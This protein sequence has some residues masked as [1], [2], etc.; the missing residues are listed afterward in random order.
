MTEVSKKDVF[1]VPLTHIDFQSIKSYTTF[2]STLTVL[3][4][5]I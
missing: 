4:S 1:Q 3:N 2:R 5:I